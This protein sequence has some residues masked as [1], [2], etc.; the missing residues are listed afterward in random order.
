MHRWRIKWLFGKPD[1]MTERLLDRQTRLIHFL[2]SSG[3]IFGDPDHRPHAVLR[4]MDR[5]ILGLEARFSFEKRM[6]KIDALL[7]RTFDLLG[8]G[9]MSLTREFVEAYPP[10]HIGRFENVRQFCDFLASRDRRKSPVP[11]YLPDVAVCELAIATARLRTEEG[12]PAGQYSSIEGRTPPRSIRRSPAAVLL[13][14]SYDIRAIFE[15][16]SEAIDPVARDVRLAIVATAGGKPP[17]IFELP[18]AV[19]DLLA[20]LDAWADAT[21]FGEWADAGETMAELVRARLLEVHR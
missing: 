10:T 16:A 6:K 20:V 17:E 1:M 21:T 18:P 8:P 9:R 4:G 13:R 3:A 12:S 11:P 5:H 14:V 15:S 19:F 2:T 7:P